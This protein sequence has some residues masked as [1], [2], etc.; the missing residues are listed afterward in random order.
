[1]PPLRRVPFHPLRP[2]THVGRVLLCI[3]L[4]LFA[5][6]L[7]LAWSPSPSTAPASWRRRC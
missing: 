6:I 4:S 2:L 1:M 3:A 7:T 5:A